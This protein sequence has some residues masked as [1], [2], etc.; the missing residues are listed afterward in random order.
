MNFDVKVKKILKETFSPYT[1]RQRRAM[2]GADM[3][4]KIAKPAVRIMSQLGIQF[5]FGPIDRQLGVGTEKQITQLYKSW[6]RDLKTDVVARLR[7]MD[8]GP[9]PMHLPV[10]SHIH[11][12]ARYV[13]LE[14][15]AIQFI[16]RVIKKGGRDPEIQ[17]AI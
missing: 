8:K 16:L 6:P 1:I 12:A 4:I 17:T 2:E 9:I 11:V 13:K 15:E 14:Q 10:I 5:G 7:E 3:L